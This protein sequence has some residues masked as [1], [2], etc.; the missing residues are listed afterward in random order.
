[1]NGFQ[2]GGVGSGIVY[3]QGPS[4]NFWVSRI[5]LNGTAIVGC[6]GTVP[7][8]LTTYSTALRDSW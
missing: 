8:T 3:T 5:V 2:G 7:G 1:M 4:G 6:I